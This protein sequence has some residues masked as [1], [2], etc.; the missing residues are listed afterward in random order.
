MKS[1]ILRTSKKKE[2]SYV[3]SPECYSSKATPAES[4]RLAC[5][6]ACRAKYGS[7]K[8]PELP[9][10]VMFGKILSSHY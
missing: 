9:L 10:T 2:E 5:A 4:H 7:I 1:I 6:Q 3:P 8:Y